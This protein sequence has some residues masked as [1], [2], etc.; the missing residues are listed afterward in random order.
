MLLL[1]KGQIEA[2]LRRLGEI[3]NENAEEVNLVIIGGAAMALA[4]DAR[5]STKDVDAVFISPRDSGKLRKWIAI[6]AGEMG[7]GEDWL[8]DAAKGFMHGISDGP[9]VFQSRG[10]VAVRPATEQLLALK[11]S[12]Y[13][14]DRDIDDAKVLLRELRGENEKEL[15]WARI[16]PFVMIGHELKSQYAFDEVWESLQ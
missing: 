9:I 10:M 3:A 6:V 4:F 16:R 12:A 14:D 7:L 8:N 2:A 1:T 11:L 13:R 5:E 15:I